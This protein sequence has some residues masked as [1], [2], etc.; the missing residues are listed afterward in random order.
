MH[1][2]SLRDLHEGSGWPYVAS[3]LPTDLDE[4]AY[5]YGA[6]RRCR[7]VPNAEALV[8]MALAYAVSDLSLKDVAAWASSLGIA[9][10]SG[11]GLFYR[12]REAESWLQCVL[13]RVLDEE[14]PG[15]RRTGVRIRAVDATVINGPR[16][17][18]TQWR[19]HVTTDPA[20]GRFN[21]VEITDAKGGETLN[22][23]AHCFK[24]GELVLGDR[25]YAT[26]RGVD[27][28]LRAEANVVVRVNPYSIRIC[29]LEKHVVSI[30][31]YESEVPPIG[32]VEF[33][34]V[35]PVPPKKETQSHKI[36][37]LKQAIAWHNV[38]IMAA[39]TRDQSVIW[40]LTTLP[41]TLASVT[42]IMELYRLRWQI[43]LLFKR[44]KSLLNLDALPSRE[45]PTARSWMLARF[46]AAALAQNLITPNNAFSPWG[47]RPMLG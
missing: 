9:E 17:D 24:K 41:K 25:A 26:A 40:L 6:L 32:G 21:S 2:E 37:P 1:N 14:I 18:G 33:N 31:E 8:R 7:N 10:I 47:Y 19:A 23:E 27:A 44:L 20:T 16:P 4:S 29:D 28:V 38:R 13:A 12:V 11:P 42:D 43:E 15:S 30:P 34:F 35:I 39:R 36:W 46:L 22:R 3:F 5:A 45:G